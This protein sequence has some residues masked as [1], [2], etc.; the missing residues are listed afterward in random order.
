M[1]QDD[2]HAVDRS[3]PCGSYASLERIYGKSKSLEFISP[4]N[5]SDCFRTTIIQ[6][7]FHSDC[8]FFYDLGRPVNTDELVHTARPRL[9]TL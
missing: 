2:E 3:T 1:I 9:Y 6:V 7:I 5:N 4:K 8:T